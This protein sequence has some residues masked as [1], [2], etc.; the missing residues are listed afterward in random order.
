MPSQLYDVLAARDIL[1]RVVG[2]RGRVRD[3]LR[4]DGL[5]AKLGSLDRSAVL[6]DL[7]KSTR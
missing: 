7:L 1:L 2:A 4:N 5:E 3:L 6:D